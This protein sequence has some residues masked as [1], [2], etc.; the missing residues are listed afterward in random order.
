VDTFGGYDEAIL[1]EY[2][3]R[4]QAEN[5]DRVYGEYERGRKGGDDEVNDANN[6]ERHEAKHDS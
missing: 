4:G 6:D 3:Q 5:D 2:E 1:E